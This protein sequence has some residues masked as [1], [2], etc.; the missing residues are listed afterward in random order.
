MSTLTQHLKLQYCQIKH[1]TGQ[2][3]NLATHICCL[4]RKDGKQE[5]N[6]QEGY[7]CEEHK[8]NGTKSLKVKNI[9][10]FDQTIELKRVNEFLK[11][12]IG[13]NIKSNF[14]SA[15]YLEARYLKPNGAIMCYQNH[16]R[17][18]KYVYYNQI[19][20]IY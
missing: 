8:N 5:N 20:E 12:L 10:N 15:R 13:K 16:S 3:S 9:L 11:S 2:C 7:R 19:Q 17:K 1:G 14:H 6:V 4:I 18:W